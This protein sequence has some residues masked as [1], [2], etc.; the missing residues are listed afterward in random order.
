VTELAAWLARQQALHPQSIDLSLER[1]TAVAERLGLVRPRCPVVTVGGTNGKGSTV[2]YCESLLAATGRRVGTFT[3]PHLI[4]YNERIRVAGATASDADIVA[5]FERIETARGNTSL[6]FFEFNTLAAL[7]IF[8]EQ[9]VDAIVLEVGLGGR[10][11]ATNLVSADVAVVCSIGFDHM[12]WLGPTLESIG[13]EKAG[14]FRA[15]R[16]A[17]LGSAAMPASIYASIE[18][19]GARPVRPDTEFYVRNINATSFDF[20]DAKRVWPGLSRPGLLGDIQV[21]NAATAI[22][23]L[24]AGDLLADLTREAA[25]RAIAN[26]RIAGRFQIVQRT[27]EWIFDVAHNAPAAQMLAAQL[28]ARPCAGRT[29]AVCGILADKDVAAIGA[30]LAGAI[31]YWVLAPLDGPRSLATGELAA[32][33]GLSAENVTQARSVVDACE[34]AAAFAQ[35]GDRIVVFGSF[36]LVG[37]ALEHLQV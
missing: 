9:G 10:L 2:A 30:S 25:S 8:A 34:R 28:A 14:I 15:G 19:V 37:P 33:L 1:V 26:T 36:H 4:R 13:R 7:A 18:T 32:R 35:Q 3:S 31:D 16:P 29:L 12:E 27:G 21:H 24:S 23:A 17:V 22:A 20:E 5:A 11:D 6:T